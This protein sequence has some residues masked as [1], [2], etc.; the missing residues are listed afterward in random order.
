V[1]KKI[2]RGDGAIQEIGAVPGFPAAQPA[3]APPSAVP[4]PPGAR[5]IAPSAAPPRP[6]GAAAPSPLAGMAQKGVLR[7]TS[8]A[9]YE[10][11]K[12][13]L[14]VAEQEA[15]RIKQE[16]AYLR[17]EQSKAGYEEGYRKGYEQALAGL[18]RLEAETNSVFERIEPQI[19][20]LAVKVAEK[21]V[22]A[23]LTSRPEAIAAIVAQALKTVR[24][25]K[26]IS[27]RVNSAHVPALEA[28]KSTLLGVLSRARDVMIRADD[29]MRPGGCVIESE[30]GTLDADLT[31]QLEML[32]RVLGGS[33][34]H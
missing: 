15:E 1:L 6:P 18:A 10:E 31:T 25:Q 22:G 11:A 3:A 12:Q 7:G 30:L 16:A 4:L 24:H 5:A 19:V 26:D 21:I 23:E 20:K 14:S 17:D 13:I 2:V 28:R 33:R 32:E 29:S 27:I 9:A 34:G 8:F